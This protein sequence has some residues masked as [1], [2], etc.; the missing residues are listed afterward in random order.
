MLKIMPLALAIPLTLMLCLSQEDF[1]IADNKENT[2]GFINEIKQAPSFSISSSSSSETG[3]DYFYCPNYGPFPLNNP[4][5]FDAT[6]TYQFYS[7]P[8]QTI[9]ERIRLF[10]SNNSVVASSRK[11]SFSYTSGTRKSVTFTIP[12]KD[13]WSNNG[14]TLKFEICNAA[15]SV[16]KNYS[17]TFYPPSSSTVIYPRLK[18][19]RY[20]S[21]GLGFYG[22]SHGLQPIVETYDFRNTPDYLDVDY[23]YRFNLLGILFNYSGSTNL[24]ANSIKLRFNDEEG[25]FPYFTH[26]NNGDVSVPLTLYK[27]NDAYSFRFTYGFYINKKTL[28]MSDTYQAGYVSTYDFYLPINGKNIFNGKDLYIDINGLGY[29]QISTT[30]KL[31]YDVDKS[32]VGLCTDGEYCVIGGTY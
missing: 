12:I 20:T 25:L 7:V 11:T 23:Y 32:Y 27:N 26:L 24:T 28:Q 21:K 31:K 10:N 17:V 18:L 1:Q 4:K 22:D 16:L 2:P 5:D 30:V 13:Y 29:D 6:F 9:F 15:S 14:L 3:E 8:S 19:K